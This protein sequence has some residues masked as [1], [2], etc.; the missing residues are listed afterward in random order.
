MPPL[1][2]SST[3][4][5]EHSRQALEGRHHFCATPSRNTSSNE[6]RCEEE[7]EAPYSCPPED[8]P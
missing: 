2:L 4:S 8:S 7:E 5:R 3:K 6:A 1:D